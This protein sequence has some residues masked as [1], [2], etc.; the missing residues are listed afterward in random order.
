MH[1]LT[2]DGTE[3]AVR[4]QGAGAPVILL[5]S[6]FVADGF[7]P[8]F[9]QPALA[10]HRLV[11]YHRRGYGD[12]RRADGPVPLSRQAEDAL[13]VMDRLGIERAHF[14]GHSY[15]GD[16]ALEVALAAPDAV[17]GLVL[18][19][20]LLPFALTPA[21][22]ATVTA[23]AAT[24]YDRLQR[25]DAAGAVD[26]F[27]TPA[28]DPGYRAALERALPGAF[29]VAVRDVDAPFGVELPALQ[30]WPRGPADLREIDAPA[31]S[32]L[33]GGAWPGFR[34]T[35]EALLTWLPRC[36]ELLLPGVGHLLPIADP[37]GV[38]AGIAAFLAR[39]PAVAR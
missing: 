15:G 18:L 6:G 37:A 11:T 32:V 38:A 2:I 12:S 23:A 31:L 35:H 8:L 19:E 13:A 1:H 25:G 27:L 33:G 26:A 34:E 28:F 10:E 22:A 30:E 5:H 9:G 36:G 16:I 4:D 20:P 7:A 21:T 17:A 39:Q 14:V 24:A 3:L 29:D